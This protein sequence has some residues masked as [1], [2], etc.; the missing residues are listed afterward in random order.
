MARSCCWTL[1]FLKFILFTVSHTTFLFCCHLHLCYVIT[2]SIYVMLS[3]TT[4]MLCCTIFN[5]FSTNLA[6]IFVSLFKVILLYF[7]FIFIY[8]NHLLLSYF[9]GASVL[10]LWVITFGFLSVLFLYVTVFVIV[11]KSVFCFHC[12]MLLQFVLTLSL[13]I[14][15]TVIDAAFYHFSSHLELLQYTYTYIHIHLVI[16]FGF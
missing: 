9:I 11:G 7:S 16:F 13:L 1:Q 3:L 2:Y 6:F 10:F 14:L 5:V 4:F 12:F 15:L 8:L